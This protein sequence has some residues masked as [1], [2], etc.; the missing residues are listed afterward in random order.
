MNDNTIRERPLPRNRP[1]A[2]PQKEADSEIRRMKTDMEENR[3]CYIPPRV[4]VKQPDKYLHY[5]RKRDEGSFRYVAHADYYILLRS[6]SNVAQVDIRI[7]HNGVLGLG[8]RLTW[9][10]KTIE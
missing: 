3:F 8:R 10:E 5:N 2:D 6:C 7:M 4:N 1:A 9:L